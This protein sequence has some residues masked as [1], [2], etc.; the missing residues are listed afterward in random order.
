MSHAA[1]SPR[2]F[3]LGFKLVLFILT[4]TALVFAAGFSYNYYYSRELLLNKAKEQAQNQAFS[5]INEIGAVL[6][7]AEQ[8]PKFL[9]HIF[10]SDIPSRERL[11]RYLVEFV[12]STPAVFGAAAAFDA[13]A[14]D[15]RVRAY[16]PYAYRKDGAV[17]LT[18]LSADSYNYFLKDWYQVPKV[19]RRPMWSEPYY[20]KGGGD[21]IMATFSVPFRRVIAGGKDFAG[22]V[23]AD[24]SLEWL[25]QLV[26]GIHMGRTG[27][28]FLLSRNG[29]F[30][31]ANH[32]EYI[33]HESI[34]SLAE[35]ANNPRIRLL[36][37]NMIS[38]EQGFVRVPD[39]FF[40]EPCRLFYGPL[41]STG[42]SLG[43]V[44]PES[45]LFSDLDAL[46]R[47]VLFICGLG[48]LL[49]IVIIMTISLSITRPIKLLASKTGEIAKGNLDVDLPKVV[50]NDEVGDLTRS[51]DGMRLAL[52]EYISNL[53]ETTKA[54]ERMESELKIARNIQMNFLPKRFPPFPDI[55]AFALH[56]ALEPAWEV[57]GDLYDFFLLDDEHLFFSV[58]D[59]SGKG[60]PAALFMAVSKTLVKGIAEQ[61]MDPALILAKVNKE[62][63]QDNEAMLFVTMFC[64][65]LNFSTGEV[66]Y[67]NAGHNPPLVIPARG[68]IEWLSLP[69]GFF[70]GIMEDG[71]YENRTL[72]LAPGDKLL[73]YT[74]GVT[75][76]MDEELHLYSN[77]RLQAEAERLRLVSPEALDA[78]VMA[79]VRAFAG[80]APQADDITILTLEYKG[81][82]A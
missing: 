32:K 66:V 34:F 82:W 11:E 3:S 8:V 2:K 54:K 15:A 26:S 65:I 53:T 33:M 44:L 60:V 73:I 30:V 18:Q 12:A 5:A 35:R 27:R 41:Q 9:A 52:K 55:D 38:G 49:L 4:G 56:A 80:D 31:S 19:L 6:K 28:G 7:D 17:I 43:V 45:E 21:A 58:G 69:H 23:T 68:E 77:E 70:L 46:S 64:G 14:Y 48:F 51:F 47:E 42:W 1:P 79:S 25:Q 22:V 24:I 76:A 40:G 16:A 75:E 20:D 10:E 62:L 13:Y 71:E 81:E 37:R 67:S 74:D 59:V 72:S 39:V 36:G 78:S 61:D 57:G 29:V 50:S 63:C